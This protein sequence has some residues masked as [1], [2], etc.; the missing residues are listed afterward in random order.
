M[1]DL[2]EIAIFVAVVE[3]GSFTAAATTLGLSQPAVS[4]RVSAL[5]KRLGV[6]LLQRS[7]RRLNLTEAGAGFFHRARRG[8]TELAEAEEEVARHQAEP[9]GL[10][11]IT[12]PVAF[13]VLHLAPLLGAFIARYPG[14]RPELVLDDGRVDLLADGFD[15][16]IRIF[17]PEDSGLVAHRLA[18]SRQAVCATPEYLQRHGVPARPDDLVHHDCIVYTNGRSPGRW[19]FRDPLGRRSITVPVE[20]PVRSNN[21]HVQK[22]AALAG[23]GLVYLPTFYVADELRA[24]TL[25]AVLGPYIPLTQGIYAVYPERRGLA[26]KVKAFVN[27]LKGRFG[28]PPY[29]DRDLPD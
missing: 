16:A 20:G 1:T 2:S 17:E 8:L 18:P 22:A 28:D 15:M 26:P 14:V 13:T 12:A 7:S 6:R 27:F 10:L 21:G 4:R 19:Q 5:E 23:L 29:W 9:R 25:R 24:G 11:R 3:A